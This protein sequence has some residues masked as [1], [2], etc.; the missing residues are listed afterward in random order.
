MKN[1]QT[2]WQRRW[3]AINNTLQLLQDRYEPLHEENAANRENTIF[4]V[5]IQLQRFG[6]AQ[7]HFFHDGFFTKNFVDLGE[8]PLND[9]NFQMA[10]YIT[11]HSLEQHVLSNTLD[12]IAAD[13]I[14]MQRASE[15]RQ[16]S[17]QQMEAGNGDQ[18]NISLSL[19]DIDKLAFTTLRIV[20][21]YLVNPKETALTY[22]HKSAHVRVIP[23]APVVMI[24]I[25][26]TAMGLNN[27]LGVTEDLLAIP[28]EVAHHLYWNGKANA[29]Q[30]IQ[31][32]L[33]E[34]IGSNQVQHWTEEIFADVVG[35]LI[36]GPAVARS[37]LE[38]QLTE[39]GPDFV[40]TLGGH[41][42]PALRPFLYAYTLEAMGM[43]KIAA[44]IRDVWDIQLQARMVF[45]NR[46]HLFAAYEIV[47]AVLAVIDQ[48]QLASWLRW[49]DG[50]VPYD[51]LYEHFAS[52]I[53]ELVQSVAEDDL[54]PEH[55]NT[56]TSWL[57][58]VTKLSGQSS[59]SVLPDRWTEPITDFN[60]I[61]L[62]AEA[63][64]RI[65]DFGGWI[66]AGP[67]GGGVSWE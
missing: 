7:F 58:L 55:L 54:D 66:T 28:H 64:L 43:D 21:P 8:I 53:P 6:E 35:C 52:R 46:S 5:L 33:T 47:D 32:E 59:L 67:R 60:T 41:P 2:L 13:T 19:V 14:V 65:Y 4:E 42:T 39:I 34:K 12:Q 31:Q 16:I 29:D 11:G 45:V 1:T 51:E 62:D 56:Q 24:G 44:E 63:W 40:H 10:Q 38:L 3:A 9:S 57:D 20:H 26:I 48:Q 18:Q 37:F 25:P 23:Y 27:G 49:S 61:Q 50:D 15:Q 30:T 22:F 36:G 17:L